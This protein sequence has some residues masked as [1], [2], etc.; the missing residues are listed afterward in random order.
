M[1]IFVVM[2]PPAAAADID[3]RFVRDGFHLF[4]FLIP[5]VWFLWHGLWIEAVVA[6]AVTMAVSALATLAGLGDAAALL[7][8]LVSVY[9][10]LEASNLR[11]AAL[12]RGGW[13]EW[14]VVEAQSIAEAE[15]RQA[16]EAADEVVP[17]PWQRGI[18]S[19]AQA[20]RPAAAMPG[21]GPALGMLDYPG[22]R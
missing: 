4:A 6:L 16:V 17:S 22:Q 7:A 5:V 11:L 18:A 9:F 10:G 8:A 13:R 12:R 3:P 14:G 1:A 19:G 2:E 20:G 15:A 21:A